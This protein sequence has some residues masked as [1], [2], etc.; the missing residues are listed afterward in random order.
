MT[1]GL[2]ADVSR[3]ILAE[4]DLVVGEVVLDELEEVLTEKFEVPARLVTQV[5]GYLQEHEVQPRP[6]VVESYPLRDPDDAVVLAS[7]IAAEAD[8]LVTGDRD[9]LDVAAR[10]DRPRILTPRGFWE[11][12]RER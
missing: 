8:I 4:H 10:M 2:S 7:A 5:L 3:L 11:V 6:E 12:H 9:L 1:R